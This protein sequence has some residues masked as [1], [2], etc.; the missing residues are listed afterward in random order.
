MVFFKRNGNKLSRVCCICGKH[1]SNHRT[2][3]RLLMCNTH[4]A[5]LKDVFMDNP[6]TLKH[7]LTEI[8]YVMK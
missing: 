3:Y 8:G 5:M 7:Y 2:K 1:L 6:L 4:R